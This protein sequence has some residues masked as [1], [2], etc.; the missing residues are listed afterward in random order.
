MTGSGK[1]HTMLGPQYSRFADLDPQ[2]WGVIPRVC[3]ALL[4]ECGGAVE[5][6]E[7]TLEVSYLELYQETLRDLL[8]P[9]HS[10]PLEIRESPAMGVFVT[11]AASRVRERVGGRE[12]RSLISL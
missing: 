10:V 11:N 2:D 8:S 9:H 12:V 5:G 1:S 7:C 4:R 3:A 6:P